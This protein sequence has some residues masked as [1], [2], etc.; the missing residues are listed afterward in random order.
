[1]ARKISDES[2]HWYRHNIN[3]WQGSAEVMALSSD[4]YKAFHSLLMYQFQRP[5]G[6][7]PNDE[8]VL[9]IQSRLTASAWEDCKAEV[10]ELFEPIGEGKIANMPMY[11]EW[12]WSRDH[13]E[14][15]LERASSGGKARKE[16]REASLKSA[17]ST[18]EADLERRKA[19]LK[20]ATIQN[21]T[22]QENKEQEIF[23]PSPTGVVAS[24]PVIFVPL[25]PRDGEFPIYRSD[26]D[27]LCETYPAVNVEQ[28]LRELV[29]WCLDNPARRKTKAGVRKF[30][31]GWMSR[32]QDKGSNGKQFNAGQ[33][34]SDRNLAALREVIGPI[35]AMDQRAAH[36]VS[37]RAAGDDI[38]GGS[39]R[40][41]EGIGGLSPA[42]HRDHGAGVSPDA[43]P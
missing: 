6:L 35:P 13:R 18:P 23:A 38:G 19:V 34:K 36:S 32:E 40:V 15:C 39:A 41:L 5:D 17:L 14:M 27:A 2:L 37:Q 7:L 24:Q 30:I 11:S 33:S 3:K 31:S 16:Q 10:L 12:E 8:R 28:E 43:S 22:E 1:M 21:N 4:G 25:I 9:R 29:R 20:S 42:G 26:V